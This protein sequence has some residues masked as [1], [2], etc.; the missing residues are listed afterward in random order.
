MSQSKNS[1][2]L[3]LY[4]ALIFLVALMMII[5]SFFG[6]GKHESAKEQA[7]TLTER[8]TAVS[9]ENLNL[10][11]KV[12]ELE[13]TIK[14]NG[15]KI[16]EFEESVKTK[17]GTIQTLT[18][19]SSI[20]KNLINAYERIYEGKI[21]EASAILANIDTTILSDDTLNFYNQLIN[22]TSKGE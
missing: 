16:T 3:F 2:S 12:S 13:D 8:A 10:T 22:L 1:S 17:D 5:L 6:S 19:E 20:Y 7:K 14:E 21:E 4:T 9:E 18:N 11:K 15:K